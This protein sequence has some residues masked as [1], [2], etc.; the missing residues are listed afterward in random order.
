MYEFFIKFFFLFVSIDDK[1]A[2]YGIVSRELSA[3][4]VASKLNSGKCYDFF[5]W[6]YFIMSLLENKHFHVQKH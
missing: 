3:E 6:F 1:R 5:C 4:T 2:I